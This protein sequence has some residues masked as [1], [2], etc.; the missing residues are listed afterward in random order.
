MTIA[1]LPDSSTGAMFS[2]EGWALLVLAAVGAG[3][4]VGEAVVCADS[5]VPLQVSTTN[6]ASAPATTVIGL[7]I[8]F[9]IDRESL[10][11]DRFLMS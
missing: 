6:S 3:S 7:L 1:V 8:E 4:E 10:T 9:N 11:R 2:E 5:S